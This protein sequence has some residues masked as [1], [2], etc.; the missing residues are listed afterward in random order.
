MQFRRGRIIAVIASLIAVVAAITVFFVWHP[1]QRQEVIVAAKPEAPPDLEKLRARFTAGVEA[2]KRGDGNEAVARLGSFSFGSRAVEQYRLLFLAQAHDLA[3]A[4]AAARATYAGLLGRSPRFVGWDEVGT[5]L[6]AK[7]AAAGDHPHAAAV[8]SSVASRSDAPAVTASA[9]W[10]AVQSSFIEGDIGAVLQNARQIAVKSPR[11]PQAADGIEVVRTLTGIAPGA[12]VPLTDAERLER[13]VALMRDGDQEHALEEMNAL[14]ATLTQ[15]DL[16]MP[17][18]LNRGLAL[19]QLRRFEDS[20]RVLEPLSSGPYKF[21]IPAL[22]TASKNYRVLSASIN[23]VVTKTI[24]VKQ[25]VGT[26]KVKPKGKKKKAVTK[27][28]YANVKKNVQLVD[29]AKKAKKEEYDRLSSERLKD[30]LSLQLA[31]EIRVEVLNTLIGIAESKNQDAF[32]RDLI[33]QL[34][35]VDP[36]QDSGLQH[37]WDKAWAAYARGDL[38]TAV[39]LCTFIRDTY[40]HPGVRRQAQYWYARSIERLGQK[41]EAA[42]I[43]R[44]LAAAPYA[45]VYAT[46]AAS[47]GAKRQET[48]TNP[49]KEKRPDWPEIAER[50]MPKELRLAYELTALTDFRDARVEIQKNLNR[51]NQPFADALM[52][53]IYNSIGD[54]LL[55]MR[56][57]K[58]AYPKLATVEQDEVPTYFLGMYYPTRYHDEIIREAKKNDLDPYVIMGLIHQESYYNPRAKSGVGATGLM[59]L[60]PATGREIAKRLHTGS[61]LE[62][63]NTNIRLGTNYFKTLV[64][65]FSG[66]VNLAIASYNAGMGNVMKWRRGAPGRPMDEF[67]ESIPFPETRNYV[68]RVNMLGASYRRLTR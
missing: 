13:A 7:Y 40:R 56:A 54:T 48:T 31:P 42:Q 38:K 68:K 52:G 9:R 11:A 30:L 24:T 16:R 33:T 28:K 10:Q 64:N 50:D 3:G 2:L 57:L 45:D 47:R 66:N 67:L 4:P 46:Y 58:R 39:E 27:P 15:A 35:K 14:D 5:R 8:A 29:L 60:M 25:K 22:Y 6:A 36:W 1:T 53:D 44:D 12:S 32:E 26:V 61:N 55:M 23:P 63:P 19:N 49:L 21:A 43:Y 20:N 34:A 59:Q 37:F 51:A 62:D 18:Q 17:L 41:D 65:M